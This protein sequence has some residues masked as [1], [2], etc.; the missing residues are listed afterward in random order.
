MMSS[1]LFYSWTTALLKSGVA[2]LKV[3][4]RYF[5]VVDFFSM[6][7]LDSKIAAEL[8]GDICQRIRPVHFGLALRLAASCTPARI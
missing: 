8:T 3:M 5:V 2:S 7:E 6:A 4:Y 1:V